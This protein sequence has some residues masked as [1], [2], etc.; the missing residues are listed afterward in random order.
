M[1]FSEK[2]KIPYHSLLSRGKGEEKKPVD[3]LRWFIYLQDQYTHSSAPVKAQEKAQYVGESRH[4]CL[5]GT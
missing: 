3:V 5:R 2:E 4:I 1:G